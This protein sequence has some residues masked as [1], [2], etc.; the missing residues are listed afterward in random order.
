MSI[1]EF[2]VKT[3]EGVKY[4]KNEDFFNQPNQNGNNKPEKKFDFKKRNGRKPLSCRIK[5]RPGYGAE[6]NNFYSA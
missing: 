4:L 6:K 3:T 2:L 1:N 5:N